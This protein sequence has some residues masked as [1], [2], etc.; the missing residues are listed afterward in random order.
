MVGPGTVD[1]LTGAYTI[2]R[3]DVSIPVPGTE[4]KLEFARTYD[5]TIENNL[6]GFSTVLGSWWQPSAPVEA[7]YSEAWVKLE[8]HV[9]PAQPA[10]Y[11]KECWDEEEEPTGCGPEC[12]PKFCEEWLAE[13]ARPEQRW[14][15]LISSEGTATPF[16]IAGESYFAPD[17]AKELKLKREGEQ[18]VLSDPSG[19]HT[20]FIKED[21]LD[22]V[23]KTI[24]FQATPSSVRM[25]YENP[26]HGEPLRLIKMI[27]P[28]P[29]GVSCE[30]GSSINTPGCRTL[31]FE[32]L[33]KNEWARAIYPS[34]QVNLASI[35]Y[36]N[37]TGNASTSQ[38][39]AKYNYDDETRL[40]E[41]W[42]PRISPSLKEKYSYG[43]LVPSELATL[44]P[45]GREPWEF[46][47]Y[48]MPERALK[49]VSRPS[50]LE[51]PTKATTT[52]VYGVPLSGDGAPYD[53]SAA[54]VAN[55]GQSDFP[56]DATAIFPPTQVP[57]REGTY[58]RTAFGTLGSGKG[59]LSSPHALATDSAGNVW[60]ADTENSRIE[61]FNAKGEFLS[62]FGSLGSG[63]GQLNHPRGLVIDAAG[64]I[65][66]AD[67]GNNRVQEFSAEGKYMTQFGSSG[68]EL[69]K[70]KGPSGIAIGPGGNIWVADTG[71]NRVEE[72][73]AAGAYRIAYTSLSSPSDITIGANLVYVAD[74]GNN[75]IVVL[76]VDPF[77]SQVA[78]FGQ[79]G[80]PGAGD[81]Q[82]NRPEGVAL[83][84]S[85]RIWVADTGNNRLEEFNGEGR[86]LA[87]LGVA[88]AEAGKFK[89][90][91][92]MVIGPSGYFWI[93][94]TG[95]NR[96]QEWASETPAVT[97]Y[98]QATIHYMDP[99]GYEVNTA[100]APPPGASGPSITTTETDI[101]GNVL[102]ELGAQN[103][104]L[105]LEAEASAP[106]SRELDTHSIYSSDGTEMLESWGPLHLVRLEK[107]ETV[108]ARLHRTVKYDE[109][110]PALKEGESAP[111][112]PT[113]ETTGAAIAGRS[114]DADQH[115]S[116]YRYN[117]TLRK[118]TESIVDP[119]GLNIRRVT[120]YDAT[121]LLIEARQPS[122][123]SGGG[124][125]T[126][127]TVYYSATANS[128]QPSCGQVPKYAGLPCKVMPA[129]Q[130]GTAGQPQLLV[131]TVSSYNQLDEPTETSESPGGGSE[132]VRRTILTYDAAGR[133]T[134]KKIE[135]GGASIP[136][137]ETLYSPSTGL[138]TAEQFLCAGSESECASFDKQTVTTTYDAL[139]RMTSYEDA[140][141]N[142]ATTTYDLLGRPVT[143]SDGK[144]SQTTRYD[145]QSGLPVK[146]E[147]SAA[148]TFTA[149]YN[150]DG[151]LVERSL[152]DGLT[153][154]T[155]FNAAGEPVH[156]TYTKQSFCGAS[157]TWLDF[158]LQRSIYGQITSE[159][160]SLGTTAYGY[161]RAGRLT[162]AE[163]TPQGGSCTARVYAYDQDSN[164][165]S[166][167][168]RS[169]GLGEG[170][171]TSGGTSQAYEYDSA[172]RLL[173][174][175]LIYDSFGRITKLPGSLAGGKELTT[176][177]FA[178]D[179]VASQ[180][181]GGVTN[182]FELD[183]ALR[184]RTRLQAGGLEGSEVFH[185]DGPSD[186]P[187][188]TQR[189]STW[190]RN[191]VGIGGELSAVQESGSEIVLELTD[192]H[193]DI[194]ATAS[195]SPEAP[196]LKATF[197]YE[198]FGK[199]I[200]GSA[201]RYGWLGA[202]QRRAEL[203]SGV[204]QMGMR[205]YVP[206]IGRFLSVDP[207][208]GGSANSYDY[209]YADPVN[210]LD[211]T[212][213]AACSFSEYRVIALNRTSPTGHFRLRV[214]AYARCGKAAKDV[215]VEAIIHGGYYE[216]APGVRVPIR[217]N[218]GPSRSCGNGGPKF[219][220]RAKA[221][222]YLDAEPPCGKRWRGRLDVTI[223]MSWGTR[224]GRRR[225]F[226]EYHETSLSV[227]T[228]CEG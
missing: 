80:A 5:S 227:V 151:S 79:F 116:E 175:G 66:V 204:I 121:G 225:P 132:N 105:A 191:I 180:S 167:T 50:L 164:R 109:G 52:I 83:E 85:N 43:T 128:E 74:T 194:A 58:F 201:G 63:E 22:Y 205:S 95:N 152:P 213:E 18:I 49:T 168:T 57:P 141:G 112:L 158:G 147:D 179:M 9:V 183:A 47:Y 140:D 133:Q 24:S 146:L 154:K 136:K 104:L 209:A 155:T 162:S 188:W 224:S 172:D 170:C 39:V 135:G 26:E 89:A 215:S 94:D 7:E 210:G 117:W 70:L 10:V 14:M 1:L 118:Q 113:K 34:W 145:A 71:N 197:S 120:A 84:G 8:E 45:P 69:G 228:L 124:A 13:E 186:A 144:G 217:G 51:S 156:L 11:E 25:V 15:E 161:D 123:P 12:D 206:A 88:G 176:S 103:R 31:L 33:P 3:T 212:G 28:S 108:E 90:P 177:Y 192:L 119:G 143:S 122:N 20:S 55:W 60:I 64:H 110:A 107:G 32:Y 106:R 2:H 139:G 198:E 202:K 193:G 157:C 76:S 148:G 62:Q 130:P 114:G 16:E 218:R 222:T 137:V 207:M 199:P 214:Q 185:Y 181:Q 223:S 150:A 125:G 187:V 98:S 102:R 78:Y 171:A 126:S 36:Y 195:I 190:T 4:A 100:S 37:A 77:G 93:A 127:K 53:M 153:A 165:T 111:R 35:R 6:P 200:S 41:E 42:D 27:G 61:E 54:T 208:V 159:S 173:A 30:D 182:T 184:Q 99:D 46:D 59:Q 40:T 44:T 97:D 87:Q 115:L 220:C 23:P 56:V 92:D 166:L 174:G 138:P 68:T 134:A 82:L 189:G 216:P 163:E 211:L 160:G 65:W 221:E 96:V 203:P 129:A 38:V 101:H 149:T 81:G 226:S 219:S 131:R 169:V 67:T 21:A 72:F 86:Y 19:T 196:A 75:R 29:A 178:D 91:S 73:S 48:R 17:Y 142:K